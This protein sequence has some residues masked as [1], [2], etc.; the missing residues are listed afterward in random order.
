[1]TL[2][3][4]LGTDSL[5]RDVV[6]ASAAESAASWEDAVEGLRSDNGREA[7]VEN[8]GT[9]AAWGGAAA[10]AQGSSGPSAAAVDTASGAA[11]GSSAF[12]QTNL[13]STT[14]APFGM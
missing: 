9:A 11:N 2:A 3:T 14:A 10:A 8:F 12:E 6:S 4:T 5:M 13:G 1:M 7:A